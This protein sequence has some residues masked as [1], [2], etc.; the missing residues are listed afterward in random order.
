MFTITDDVS[1]RA[2]RGGRSPLAVSPEPAATAMEGGMIC[3]LGEPG[4]DAV[5]LV[6]G[7]AASRSR[8]AAAERVPPGFTVT[9]RA[10]A[11]ARAAAGDPGALT[12]PAALRQEIG[13]A[14]AELSRRLEDPTPVI[15]NLK[16]FITQPDRDLAPSGPRWRRS[17]TRGRR[18]AG[19]AGELPAASGG[20]V[21]V[22]VPGDPGGDGAE[23]GPRLLD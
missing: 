4:G 21:R 5:A 9:A 8:L 3:W 15:K 14:F 20:R 19:E 2:E 6:G 11:A 17:G 7:K 16:H 10:F 13:A 23:R 22:P 18:G 1:L 12:V